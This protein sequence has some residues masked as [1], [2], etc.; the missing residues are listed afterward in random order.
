L[1]DCNVDVVLRLVDFSTHQD[2]AAGIIK[3]LLDSQEMSLVDD[4]CVVWAGLG[5]I[6]VELL[7]SNLQLLDEQW[8]NILFDYDVVLRDADLSCIV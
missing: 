4:S 3:H 7:H 6:G 1:D 8:Q 5:T 2:F